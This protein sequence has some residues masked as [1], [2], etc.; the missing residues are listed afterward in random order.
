MDARKIDTAVIF[1]EL[2]GQHAGHRGPFSAGGADRYYGR[3]YAP[4]FTYYGY[5]F[6]RSEMTAQQIAEYQAG[7][8]A[9][10]ETK[11]W[12]SNDIIESEEA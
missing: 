4:N 1:R 2:N 8:N 3:E 7:W 12:G 10:M 11:D 6:N 9:E 5:K